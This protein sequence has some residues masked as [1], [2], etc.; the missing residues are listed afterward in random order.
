MLPRPQRRLRLAAMA[1]PCA[2]GLHAQV[3]G[4]G[5]EDDDQPL[6][7]E[8]THY[9]MLMNNLR[10][11]NVTVSADRSLYFP[12]EAMKLSLTVTN[13]TSQSL[14]IPDPNDP[15]TQ[16][17][18]GCIGDSEAMMVDPNNPPGKIR[19]DVH[20]VVLQPGQSITVTA[21]SEDKE[22]AERWCLGPAGPGEETMTFLIGGSVTIRTGTPLVEASAV[23][24]LQVFK[25]FKDK[26]MD[27]PETL[28]YAAL[29]VAVRLGDE[30]VIL[31]GLDNMPTRYRLKT[32]ADGTLAYGEE[33][34]GAPWVRLAT[35]RSRVAKL[36]GEADATGRITIDYTTEDG[37]GGRISLDKNRHPL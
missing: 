23:V 11:M 6:S 30:H 9:L 19:R 31:I 27:R 4:G 13:P 12:G 35:V 24:P 33:M 15:G 37:G 22:A 25:T 16:R 17:V 26:G 2:F 32:N 18:H 1:L 20:R 3:A 28:Q 5:E 36:S 34:S 21:D 29:L 14:E 8:L 10:Q 7:P